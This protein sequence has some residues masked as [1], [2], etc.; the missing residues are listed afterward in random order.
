MS[1]EQIIQDLENRKYAP[2]YFL[3]GEEPYY[4]DEIASHIE[5]HVLNETEKEFNQTIIYGKDSNI[6]S[7]V[8]YAKRFPMMANHQVVIVR[9][10][11]DLR[12]IE[13]LAAYVENTMPSTILVILYKYK[14]LDKRRSLAKTVARNGVL[15]ESARLYDNKI[16]PWIHDYLMKR[17][18]KTSPEANMLLSEHL[19][20]DL[21][22]IANELQ[23]LLLNLQAGTLITPSIVEENIGI[24][25]DFNVFELQRSLGSRNILKANRIVA[26]F[27]GN[28]KENPLIK[29]ISS[30]YP[31][32]NKLLV[33]HSLKD[34]SKNSVASALGVHPFFVGEYQQAAGQFPPPRIER[35]MRLLRTFDMKA[36]GVGNVS[37]DDGQLMKEMVYYIL[38]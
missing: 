34:K 23:K 33:L 14:K 5:E 20:N 11:Q 9:E 15:F 27:S 25:K 19:G 24:S 17:G 3:M 38:H 2:V 10:A 8:S 32:F 12:D 31:Y 22:H 36:K 18:M 4:I 30:L 13:E 21:S 37:A 6:P 29:V 35:I 7:I 1:F 28:L 16:P 26:H